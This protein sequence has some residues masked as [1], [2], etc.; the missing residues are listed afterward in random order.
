MKASNIDFD[1]ILVI[2]DVLYYFYD[3]YPYKHTV[4][5]CLLRDTFQMVPQRP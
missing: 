1:I 2:F 3:V 5:S 4:M